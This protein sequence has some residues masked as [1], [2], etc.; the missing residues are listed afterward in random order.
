MEPLQMASVIILIGTIGAIVWGKIDRAA[1]AI[2]GAILMIVA[3][4]ITE[5]EAFEFVDWNVII[6]IISMWVIAGYFG[7]TGIPE[8]LAHKAVKW[9]KGS[10]STFIILLGAMAGLVSLF[11]DNILVILIFAPVALHITRLLKT[12]PVPFLIFIGLCANFTGSALLI[13]DLPPQMLH[14]VSGIEF[15]GFIW[16]EGRP[17]SFIILMTTFVILLAFFKFKFDKMFKDDKKAKDAFALIDPE[18]GSYVSD[19][20]AAAITVGF[21]VGTIIAMS[22]R[23]YIGLQLGA[24]ALIGASLLVLVMEGLG[25][26]LKKPSFEEALM[27][28]DWR[29]VLF[30]I[31][32]FVIIGGVE[33]QG[34]IQMAA[35]A[36]TPILA[37][38]QAMGVSVLYWV[39]APIVGV[40]EHDAYILAFLYLIRDLAAQGMVN[41]WPYW[42]TILWA[43]TLGSNLTVAGAPALLAAYNLCEKEGCKVTLKRSLNYSVP[44]VV[45]S[46]VVC[47]AL[48]MVFWGFT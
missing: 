34:L 22:M 1:V 46:L 23:E 18:G 16:N 3:G 40:L 6:L 4:A 29:S 39:T 36:L 48:M 43:G 32:L 41:P 5:F 11:V 15:M 38:N 26:R 10:V 13:G 27:G 30:Y 9:S 33:K 31:S 14:S 42:W 17:S 45:I 19:K 8:M 47:Y 37:S 7:K 21:F 44:F 20:R 12:N 28:L 35:D 2:F 25:N 24:I